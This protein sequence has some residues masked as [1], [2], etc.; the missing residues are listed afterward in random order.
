ML[1]PATGCRLVVTAALLLISAS[2]APAPAPPL[3][4]LLIAVDGLEPALLESEL[5]R[6]H[7]P[8]LARLVA[9]GT[10]AEIQCITPLISPVVWTTVATGTMPEEHGILGFELDGVPVRTTDRLR[11]A[12]WNIADQFDRSTATV[13]W[14]VTWPAE[15]NAGWMI[16]DR[17]HWGSFERK[18]SPGDLIDLEPHQ[19]RSQGPYGFLE[20]FTSHPFEPSYQQ[21]D[22]DHPEYA[23]N[24]LVDRRLNRIYQRDRAY[25]AMAR[26][27]LAGRDPDLLA[28][29]LRGIDYVSHGFWQYFDPEP[30]RAEGWEISDADVEALGSVIP[31]YYAYLDE[32][33][34][35]L[36][37][38]ARPGALVVL[39][40]DHG[41]GTGLGR[42]AIDGGDFLSGN[43]R[44]LATLLVSGGPARRGVEQRRQITHLDILP[45]LLWLL[46]LP[47][48][49]D[50]QGRPLVEFFD[51]EDLGPRDLP[52]VATY[53]E[54]SARDGDELGV[55]EQDEEILEEL[56]S[57][58]Y[59]D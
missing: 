29:Y 49:E 34:G 47:Q 35:D 55:D 32:I 2:C 57:L 39:L 48:A 33:V 45:T 10:L 46:G 56:R 28:L 14:M 21:L 19:I 40:S 18:A 12:F 16:S 58:G 7:L 9:T 25:A 51:A 6:G 53:R 50:L 11:P 42:Y 8:N 37:A 17:A 20:R 43:H 22:P 13:G 44:D 24:F 38:T 31:A 59:I 1:S 15:D 36:L 27:V 30:F 26:E 3:Q 5:D 41:F 23:V 52:P 54:Q 4:V